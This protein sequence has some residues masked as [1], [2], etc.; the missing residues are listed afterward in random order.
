MSEVEMTDGH[1]EMIAALEAV[2][3]ASPFNQ[4]AGFRVTE[5]EAGAVTL[6]GAAAPELTNHAGAL[7]A[8]VQS[9]LIDTACG[10]AAGTVAGNVVTLQMNV[11]FLSSAKGDRFEARA[12]VTKAARG[13]IFAE[14]Q[15]FAFRGEEEA[16]VA[17]GTAVL[18]KLG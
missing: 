2:N 10:F 11:Q 8:G 6:A 16:L 5:A 18:A 4:L 1:A 7:H 12:R 13:Q 9:A 14:A 3:G 15:L 17:S